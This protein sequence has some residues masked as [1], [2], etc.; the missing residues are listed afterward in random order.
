MRET[1]KSVHPKQLEGQKSCVK[2]IKV[3]IKSSWKD[4]IMRKT[5]KSVHQ[6]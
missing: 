1:N 6:K 4:K 2:P 5:N 3:S